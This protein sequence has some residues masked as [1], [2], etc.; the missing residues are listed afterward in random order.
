MSGRLFLRREDSLQPLRAARRHKQHSHSFCGARRCSAALSLKAVP[1]SRPWRFPS[2]PSS[3][4]ERPGQAGILPNYPGRAR[5]HLPA[6]PAPPAQLRTGCRSHH[7][8]HRTAPARSPPWPASHWLR[9][10]RAARAA[11]ARNVP[12]PPINGRRARRL[13]PLVSGRGRGGAGAG[14]L[15]QAG[16]ARVCALRLERW[17]LG[18]LHWSAGPPIYAWA[19]TGA[20]RPSPER[21]SSA[22]ATAVPVPLGHKAWRLEGRSQGRSE[23]SGSWTAQPS[24][25]SVLEWAGARGAHSRSPTSTPRPV[26]IGRGRLGF[27]GAE[28]EQGVSTW[29]MEAL[30][31]ALNPASL[32]KRPLSRGRS[33]SG[34]GSRRQGGK[35]DCFSPCPGPWAGR[36]QASPEQLARHTPRPRPPPKL[37]DTL[38]LDSG[39][40]VQA[41]SRST[42]L[43]DR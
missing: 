21:F 25:R 14:L 17:I 24:C 12:A 11:H 7:P 31:S 26:P 29:A 33:L 22:V 43:P 28:A 35:Q 38:L 39:V 16:R 4:P 20:R 23:A 34:K 19:G 15:G 5:T 13:T 9:T 30:F 3:P 41:P 2:P 36:P 37:V 42:S 18:A 1:A 32:G 6:P 27:H 8:L 40:R 10:S